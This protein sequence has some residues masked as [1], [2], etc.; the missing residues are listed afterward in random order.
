MPLMAYSPLGGSGANLLRDPTLARIGAARGCSAAAVALAWTIRN[1]KIIAIPES[2]SPA[3]VKENAVALSL[4]L[5]PDSAF[6]DRGLGATFATSA[7]APAYSGRP[8]LVSQSVIS[9]IAAHTRL[10]FGLV[11]PLDGR[12]YPIDRAARNRPKRPRRRGD[13]RASP[14][15]HRRK[16][17]PSTPRPA[18]ENAADANLSRARRSGCSGLTN[19]FRA[20]CSLRRDRTWRH[21][22]SE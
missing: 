4:T 22:P 8:S 3:H 20:Q 9:C 21:R 2:G 16:P 11:D 5:T 12:F 10:N 14:K 1:D 19:R 17:A 15:S 6:C 7:I 13:G 18:A